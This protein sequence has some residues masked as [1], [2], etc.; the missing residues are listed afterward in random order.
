MDAACRERKVPSPRAPATRVRS[1][2]AFVETKRALR[3]TPGAYD[4]PGV[5]ASPR[6]T[7]ERSEVHARTADNAIAPVSAK[8]FGLLVTPTGIEPVLPT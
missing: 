3:G 4:R 8:D 6:R 1:P 2:K 5:D 7:T